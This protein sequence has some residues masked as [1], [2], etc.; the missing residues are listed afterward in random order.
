MR[1]IKSAKTRHETYVTVRDSHVDIV[2]AL[3]RFDHAASAADEVRVGLFWDLQDYG[4]HCNALSKA[5]AKMQQDGAN[6]A[7]VISFVL[8]VSF[9]R[10]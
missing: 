3:K 1:G 6:V 7:L 2:F 8:A 4:C 10:F 9:S 5:G